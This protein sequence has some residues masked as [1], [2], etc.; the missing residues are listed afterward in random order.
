MAPNVADARASLAPAAINPAWAAAQS[1][2]MKPN[3]PPAI[4]KFDCALVS[5]VIQHQ[6]EGARFLRQH[7]FVKIRGIDPV[8]H[9]KAQALRV[10][11]LHRRDVADNDL[12]E[13]E[14]CHVL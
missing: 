1:R 3:G 13:T 4:A 5:V 7:H 14:P 11:P 2:T 6:R 12:D 9:C 8:L 10:K